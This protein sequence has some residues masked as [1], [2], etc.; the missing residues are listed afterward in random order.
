MNRLGRFL[1]GGD[2]VV[3][4]SKL[5]AEERASKDD[6]LEVSSPTSGS[7][8]AIN[9][10]TALTFSAIWGCIQVLSETLASLPL[11]VFEEKN[12]SKIVVRDHFAYR[13]L[14]IEPNKLMTSFTWRL[15]MMVHLLTSGNAY[16]EI[17]RKGSADATALMILD[18]EK[19]VPALTPSGVLFY[20]YTNAD[21][22]ERNIKSENMLH[23]IGLTLDGINGINPIQAHKEGIETA[24]HTS[25]FSNT[26]YK[27]NAAI[28]T[29][30][31][32]PGS[33]KPDTATRIQ[34]SFDAKFAGKSNAGKT[35]VL[36][37]GM[38]LSK[39]TITQADAQYVETMRFSV[40]DVCRIY[41][42]PPHMVADLSRST[43]NNIEEQGIS[44][45]RD[46]M[47]PYVRRWEDEIN[48][49]LF[50]EAEKGIIYASFNVNGLMRGNAAARASYYSIM[51]QNKIMT[52]NE[53]R[54]LE[55]LNPVE[56]GDT[57]ENPAIAVTE[58]NIQ[59]NET[60]G[61]TG[62]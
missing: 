26:F 53:I 6:W 30:L 61:N 36:E 37:E 46:T 18:P 11:H 44:F 35:V 5:L 3:E 1:F 55:N 25:S 31:E 59:P 19:V 23:I 40:E 14:H 10:D 57:F 42:V 20:K 54:L 50:R 8:I 15:S 38:K 34:K 62:V 2:P 56:G 12:D 47:M 17:I 51:R 45:V 16:S 13:I 22:I 60:D 52:A 9:R 33:L 32:H 49:K 24:L 58:P 39:M 28:G 4:V 43:N 29:V 41:R 48:R 7:S 27:N 21:G